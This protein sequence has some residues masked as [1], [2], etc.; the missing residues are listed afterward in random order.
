MSSLNQ[1]SG[2][3][4]GVSLIIAVLA[5]AFLGIVA[6]SATAGRA[7]QAD[8]GSTLQTVSTITTPSTITVTGTGIAS[9]IPDEISIVLGVATTGPNA[10][11]ALLE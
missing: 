2:R 10:T 7:T 9:A 11:Q 6:Y 8:T 5:V 4:V 1:M 3:I